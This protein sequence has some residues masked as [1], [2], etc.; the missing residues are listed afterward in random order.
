MVEPPRSVVYT[1][2]ELI[3][4]TPQNMTVFL[5]STEEVDFRCVTPVTTD[6]ALVLQYSNG[7]TVQNIVDG[8]IR[9]DQTIEADSN[10]RVWSVHVL[11]IAVKIA[12]IIHCQANAENTNFE[13]ANAI[14]LMQGTNADNSHYSRLFFLRTSGS[15]V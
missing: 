11:T 10:G 3:E 13:A 6:V 8:S 7:S 4:E 9:F 5:N 15:C 1:F 14:L 12:T 2:A